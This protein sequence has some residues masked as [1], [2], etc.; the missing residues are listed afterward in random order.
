MKTYNLFGVELKIEIKSFWEE[1]TEYCVYYDVRLKNKVG[2]EMVY[3][4]FDYSE[5]KELDEDYLFHLFLSRGDDCFEN[6]IDEDGNDIRLD[7]F[8]KLLGKGFFEQ[9][10][11]I[12][13]LS[14]KVG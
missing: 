11:V 12:Q 3:G 5:T 6:A 2:E 1:T 8:V 9:M 10:N 4:D 14:K 7:V 13:K